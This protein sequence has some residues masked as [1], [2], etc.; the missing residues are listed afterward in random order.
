MRSAPRILFVMR[1]F[2]PIV[3]D[4]VWR[5]LNL[6]DGLRSVGW[7]PQVLTAQWHSAWPA[8]VFLRD[9]EVHRLGPSPSTPFR[10]R[11]FTRT[12]ADFISRNADQ[13]ACVVID[14][15]E[16]E[17]AS[18]TQ[19]KP[20]D[21]PPVI[22]RFDALENGWPLIE[23]PS[24]RI[25]ELCRR[26]AKVVVPHEHARRELTS[27]QVQDGLVALIPDL[28][29]SHRP[30]DERAR[31]IARRALADINHELYLRADDRL[32]VAVADLTRQS[33]LETLIRAIG[34]LMDTRRGLRC[35]IVGE[36]PDR[37]RIGELL[38]REGWRNDFVL[39]GTFEDVEFV[40]EAADLCILP[41]PAQGLAWT[42]PMAVACGTT[43]LLCASPSARSRFGSAVDPLTFSQGDSQA[44]RTMIEH[45][46]A[47]PRHFSSA[48]E[49]L[50]GQF[51]V[52]NS[53][54]TILNQLFERSVRQRAAGWAPERP[55]SS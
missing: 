5:V 23:R 22:V 25:S 46:W 14:A 15:L 6:A 7:E 40:L 19:G 26:S 1:R 54:L 35:W 3:N 18:L 29:P 24:S 51:P 16:E 50:V 47:N 45:W 49:K 8:R 39:P 27:C 43:T 41:A 28:P 34:P 53:T 33:G 37:G 36:G 10:S 11:R 55:F 17:A 4:N 44:L 12:V 2:W 20:T 38:R 9:L 21:W 52:G 30:T 48:T 42:L 31:G 32:I 13:Y